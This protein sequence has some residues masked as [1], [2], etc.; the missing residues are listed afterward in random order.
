MHTKVA[1]ETGIPVLFVGGRLDHASA[2]ELQ[3]VIGKHPSDAAGTVTVDLSEVDYLSSA[4]LKV[5]E[6]LAARRSEGGGRL[7]LRSPSTAARLALELSGLLA[8]AEPP[9][10][11]GD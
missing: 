8:L 4:A 1:E 6:A 5:F 7:L 3:I 10:G 9:E 2:A 11:K